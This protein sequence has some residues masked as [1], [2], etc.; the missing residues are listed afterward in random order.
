[1]DTPSHVYNIAIESDDAQELVDW[2]NAPGW[3]E[4]HR[5][6]LDTA[7]TLSLIPKD[8]Y[9]LP[10][11]SVRLDGSKRWVCFSRICGQLPGGQVRLYCIGWQSTIKKINVKS[12]LWVYPSGAVECADDPS[13]WQEFLQ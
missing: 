10:V 6:I 12:L 5:A 2:G 9:E 8:G 3:I 7:H 13:Y 4:Q 1:M 11:V